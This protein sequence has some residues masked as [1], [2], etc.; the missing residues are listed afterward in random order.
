VCNQIPET[1]RRRRF[2]RQQTAA[3]AFAVYCV[4]CDSI[5]RTVLLYAILTVFMSNALVAYP[6]A[7]LASP[8][9]GGQGSPTGGRSPDKFIGHMFKYAFF[10]IKQTDNH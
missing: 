1:A 7:A 9:W 4:V 10:D 6:V 2:V 8:L 5:M 3:T